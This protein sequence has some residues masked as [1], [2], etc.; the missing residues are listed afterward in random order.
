MKNQTLIM[1]S[2]E[3]ICWLLN[4]RGFD[5][6]HTPL[7]LSRL[8]VSSKEIV[9][10]VNKKKIPKKIKFNFD[11]IIKDISDFDKDLSNYKNLKLLIENQ[12]SYYIFN[13]LKKNNSLEVEND[14]CKKLKAIKNPVEILCSENAHIQDG[15]ALVKFFYWIEKNIKNK[16]SEFDAAKKLESFRK[17]GKDFFL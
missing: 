15:L 14:I 12:V 1:T 11:L 10:Y 3:S 5:L 6:P 2:P 13:T 16:I 9:F 8:I 4:V 7:V 17:E